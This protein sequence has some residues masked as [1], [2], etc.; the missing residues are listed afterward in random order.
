M[1][2]LVNLI[3]RSGSGVCWLTMT[4]CAAALLASAAVRAAPVD[5]NLAGLET[6]NGRLARDF[7]DLWFNQR[8]PE[9]AFDRYVSHDHYMNHAIYSASV[10]EP[11]TFEQEKQEEARVTP[12]GGTRFEFRQII[13]QG[14]LVFLHIQVVHAAPDPGSEL[15]ILLRIRDGKITDH[16][17]LHAP[18]K[19]DSAVFADLDR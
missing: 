15:V 7:V 4:L 6:A 3:K 10:N 13:A 1:T 18:L 9:E 12:S 2:A 14:S 19:A 17:D 16:W 5:D 8:K 11:K